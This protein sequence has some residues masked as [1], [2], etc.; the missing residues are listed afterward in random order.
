M[1]KGKQASLT[2]LLLQS[3]IQQLVSIIPE[4]VMV[5]QGKLWRIK[6]VKVSDCS[7]Q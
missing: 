6:P 5:N 4:V 3:S 2:H 7:I 1:T